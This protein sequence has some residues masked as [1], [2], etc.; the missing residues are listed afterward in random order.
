MRVVG[1]RSSEP[2]IEPQASAA[3]LQRGLAVVDAA[4]SFGWVTSTGQRKGVYRFKTFEAMEQHRLDCLAQAMAQRSIAGRG[5][6]G[7]P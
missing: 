7:K 6:A 2:A 3:A 5:A 4:A 1:R